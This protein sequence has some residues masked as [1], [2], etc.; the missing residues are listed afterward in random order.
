MI[1]V[2]GLHAFE[3]LKIIDSIKGVVP[4]LLKSSDDGALLG[5]QPGT[6][7]YEPAGFGE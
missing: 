5:H 7:G 2:F 1:D 4:L 6:F 3:Q